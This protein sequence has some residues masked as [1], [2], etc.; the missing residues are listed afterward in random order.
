MKPIVYLIDYTKNPYDLSIATARTCYSSKGIIFPEEVSNNEKSQQI[1]DKI[2]K[3]T[4]EAGHLTTR[5]HPNFIFAIDKISRHAVWSFL[6]SHPFY[7]SEQVSQRYVEVKKDQFHI[8]ASLL[9]KEK[10]LEHYKKTLDYQYRGYFDLIQFLLPEIEKNY[11]QIFPYRKKQKEKYF[12]A[13]QKKA[14]EIARYVLPVATYTYMYHTINGLTLHRYKRMSQ[15]C[16]VPEEVKELVHSMWDEVKKIDPHYANEMKDPVPLEKTPEY[17]FFISSTEKTS[18]NFIKSFDQKLNDYS[19]R[20]VG[21]NYHIKEIFIDSILAI[22]GRTNEDFSNEQE[23][24]DLVL[25]PEKNIHLQSILNEPLHSRVMRS[26]YH[27]YF[28]FQKKISHT[29]DSQDQR[30]RLVPGSR[31]VLMTHYSGKPDYIIPSVIANNSSL[32]EKYSQI[33]EQIFMYVNEFLELGA[34]FDEAVY[35]LPNAFPIRFYES[36]DL[37]NLMHKWRIRLCYNA[38]EEIFRTSVEEVKQVEEAIPFLKNYFRAP[39]YIRKKAEGKPF[40][41]EGERFCGFSVWNFELKDYLRIL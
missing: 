3:S 26:L 34:R 10:L 7:N 22:I 38:Q 19:S 31:P 36:G 29:A 13:V 4:L 2:A 27:I 25:S 39:C 9:K 14:M 32:L 21:G 41:P 11:F 37:M 8:P 40:C 12:K 24:I 15:S 18:I 17:E 30:H 28:T 23:I 5:Q 6:H 35:L 16:D 20:L 33:M 1:R